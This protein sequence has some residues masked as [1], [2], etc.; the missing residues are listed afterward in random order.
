MKMLAKA[1][2]ITALLSTPTLAGDPAALIL[3][4]S[5]AVEPQVALY[6]EV[7]DGTVLKLA[8]DATL[9]ISHYGACE[10]VALKG[11]TVSVALDGLDLDG[12]TVEARTPVECP[13]RIVMAAADLINMAVTLRSTR[14][15]A[16][17]MAPAPEFVLAGEWGRTFDTLHVYAKDGSTATI[18]VVGGHAAWPAD[19]PPLTVGE[20]YVVVLNGPGAQQHAARIEVTGDPQGMTVLQGR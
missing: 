14:K 15:K 4:V 13:D 5:G 9:T 10:E 12:S 1:F 7:G 8:G 17:L 19:A 18:P 2:A 16:R 3:D 20:T 6:D 11:G